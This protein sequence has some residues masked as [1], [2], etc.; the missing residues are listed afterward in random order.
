[1]PEKIENFI[2]WVP[3]SG[4]VGMGVSIF[5]YAGKVGIGLVTD[6]GLVPDP[7]MILKYFE[8]EFNALFEISRTGKVNIQPLVDTG[9]KN[10]RTKASDAV[11]EDPRQESAE[12]AD[13][14]VAVADSG[15]CAATTRSG[16][17]CKNKAL[18]GTNY[19]R[20]HQG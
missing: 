11:T 3:R 1:M 12:S 18:P 9:T 2:G 15:R 10:R 7:E 5:S 4:R 13:D 20:V 14:A 16:R 17:R 6:E 19:C 8:A